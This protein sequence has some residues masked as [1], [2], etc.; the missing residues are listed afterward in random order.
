MPTARPG[1]YRDDMNASDS[2]ARR[3]ALLLAAVT[4]SL[5]VASALHLSGQVTGRADLY[6]GQEAGLA[7]LVIGLV[8]AAATIALWRKGSR[9]IRAALWATGFAI[10]GFCVG[11]TITAQAG[12]WPDIAYHVTVLPLLVLSFVTLLRAGHVPSGT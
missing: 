8:L 7:E 3:L 5:A 9:A 11:L 4:A 1:K 10:V 2:L 6:D 12:H